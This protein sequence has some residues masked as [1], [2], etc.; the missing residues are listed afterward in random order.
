MPKFHVQRSIEID[1]P[2]EQVFDSVADFTT[3]PTWS[4]WLPIDA[5]AKVTYS[6]QQGA[7]DSWYRWTGDVVGQGEMQH[8]RLD[9]PRRIE[10][11]LRFIKPFKSRS[12]VVFELEPRGNTSRITWHMNGKLP[13]FLAFMKSS[14]EMYISMDYHRGLTMLKE[15]IETG[16]VL[17]RLEVVGVKSL[18]EMNMVG[19]SDSAGMESI[20]E[21]MDQAIANVHR[22]M[23][24]GSGSIEGEMISVYHPVD[25]KKGRLD[26][27][28]GYLV[29]SSFS[30]PSGLR[31]VHL[32]AGKYLQVRHIGSYRHLGNA[33]S[34][35]YQYARYKKF[36]MAKRDG[37]E[38]YRND[39]SVTPEREL[40]TDVYVPLK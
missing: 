18:S 21:V 25:L 34:G 13:F 19:A 3:W 22:A 15:Y 23:P 31:S 38:I 5:D 29:P 12:D 28:T 1:A 10:D 7:V 35:A 6:D 17:S 32:R 24:A 39:P 9:R 2:A 11:E 8:A 20:G 26:F 14:M 36:K 4:P 37:F 16:E 27:T 40:I 33:W 30:T